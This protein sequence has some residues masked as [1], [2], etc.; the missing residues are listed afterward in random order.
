MADLVDHWAEAYDW[1]A[2]EARMNRHQHFLV[3]LDGIPVHYLFV[4]GRGPDP[5][6]L[7]L[8]HGWPW[9]FWDFAR[10]VDPL[11]DPAAHGGGPAD[12]FDVIVPSLPGFGFS[13][14]LRTTGVDAQRIADL[15]VRL[16]CD[17]LGYDRFGASGGDFGAT[18][19]SQ[20]G[21]AHPDR[22][23]GIH[24]TMAT[25]PGVPFRSAPE[26]YAPDEQWMVERMRI[27]RTSE[28]HATVH[29]L[30]PQTL[31]YAMA[32]SP[33]GLGA[34]LWHR[35]HQWCGGDALDVF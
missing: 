35:R 30:D 32:D 3:E 21:H 19:T 17:V 33:A 8:S 24:L 4:P 25:V 20:L 26:A 16:A 2:A 23:V 11:A 10:V 34:W 1:R 7:V 12:S 5:L 6:P 27:Q 28:A 22:L 18:V 15:W 14:P 13:V 31:A 9:S 29:R